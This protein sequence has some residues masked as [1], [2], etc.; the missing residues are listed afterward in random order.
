[1]FYSFLPEI[2]TTCEGSRRLL[3]ETS[4]GDINKLR[5]IKNDSLIGW[6][7]QIAQFI[8]YKVK[9]GGNTFVMVV[10]FCITINVVTKAIIHS[11][12]STS[13][14]RLNVCANLRL[15]S[16]LKHITDDSIDNY[17]MQKILL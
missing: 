15:V 1:M 9:L 17:F 5:I 2:G 7:R 3:F 13:F 6:I 14:E 10:S 4:L 16:A 12:L 8:S 11:L